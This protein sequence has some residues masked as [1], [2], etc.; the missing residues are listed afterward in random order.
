MV[1]GSI[2]VG[3]VALIAGNGFMNGFLVGY[4]AEGISHEV[5]NVQIHHPEFKTD[6]D[7]K[8]PIENGIEKTNE[9]RS[10]PEVEAVTNRAIVTGMISSPQKA[11]GVQIRGI[12]IENEAKVTEL[13]SMVETG[14][15]FEGL[16]DIPQEHR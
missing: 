13:D 4:M 12:D 5:S 15:Y 8:L 3:I 9:I 11:A 6:F 14:T 2:V 10:W 1:I 7:V 16:V